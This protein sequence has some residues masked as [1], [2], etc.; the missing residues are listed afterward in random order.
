MFNYGSVVKL[1]R[2]RVMFLS[3]FLR[4]NDKF[5]HLNTI[6]GK[7]G[8]THDLDWWLVGKPMS[9]FLFALTELLVFSLSIT[10][11]EL[12]G[13]RCTAR[14]FSQ[15]STSLHLTFI[16][17]GSS[18]SS[19]LG[20]RKLEALG[21]PAVKAASFCVPSFWHNTGVWPVS[22]THLTLPTILRV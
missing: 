14:L 12:W 18:P 16:W 3:K 20:I 6:L 9:D 17:T 5:G 7:P 19:I 1:C 10:V 8:M 21:Y 22:Y 11:P 13:E 15:G 4:K 2:I